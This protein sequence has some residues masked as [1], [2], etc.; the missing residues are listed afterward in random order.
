MKKVIV[1][2]AAALLLFAS[3]AFAQRITQDQV[4]SVILNSFQQAFPKA[5]D[6]EWRKNVNSY[7]VEFE[8]GIFEDDHDVWYDKSGKMLKHD[9]ELPKRD[10]PKAII[11]TIEKDFAGYKV[12]EVDKITEDNTVTYHVEIEK[13]DSELKVVFDAKGKV[14][15]Q[16]KD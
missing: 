3:S 4:P 13:N 1:L 8:I 15:S 12:D 7:K 6:I 11:S 10:L 9:E 2:S 5:T 16:R 14:I